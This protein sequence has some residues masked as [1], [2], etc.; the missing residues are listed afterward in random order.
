MENT[1]NIND[2]FKTIGNNIKSIRIKQEKSIDMLAKDAKVSS[3]TIERYEKGEGIKI[4]TLL[5][6]AIALGTTIDEIV[7]TDCWYVPQGVNVINRDVGT[8]LVF[9]LHILLSNHFLFTPK[10]EN[11]IMY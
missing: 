9:V 10:C 6:I 8:T 3:K 7:K 5:G 2:V 1:N 4:E 11:V